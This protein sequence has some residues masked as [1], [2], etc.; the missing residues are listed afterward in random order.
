MFWQ[1][2]AQLWRSYPNNIGGW[3][4]SFFFKQVNNCDELSIWLISLRFDNIFSVNRLVYFYDSISLWFPVLMAY[5]NYVRSL[6]DLPPYIFSAIIIWHFA[7]YRFQLYLVHFISFAIFH[8]CTFIYINKC[9]GHLLPI[10]LCF[11][12][13]HQR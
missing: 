9:C 3:Q 8:I 7:K 11:L 10:I 13:E 5:L 2:V 1:Q 6:Y 12:Y 4:I